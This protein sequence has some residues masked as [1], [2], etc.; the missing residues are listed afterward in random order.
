MNLANKLQPVTAWH[1]LGL[2]LKVPI[3]E[4]ERIEQNHP[5][6]NRRMVEVLKYWWNN[7]STEKRSWKTIA[8]ALRIIGH[9]NLAEKLEPRNES[10]GKHLNI[11][12][13]RESLQ[14]YFNFVIATQS[15]TWHYTNNDV[16]SHASAPHL[17]NFMCI[18][19]L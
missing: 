1:Q 17:I 4:L 6:V 11:W 8:N 18:I 15:N 14:N 16:F 13:Y 10:V 2:Q 12:M 7:C 19:S 5:T 3:D 9:R